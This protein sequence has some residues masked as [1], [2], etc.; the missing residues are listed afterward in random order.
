M[1]AMS[2]M[3]SIFNFED[4]FMVQLKLLRWNVDQQ[5]ISVWNSNSQVFADKS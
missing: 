2:K 3:A 5:M 1:A 4:Y